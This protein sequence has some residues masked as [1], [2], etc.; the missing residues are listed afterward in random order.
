[1]DAMHP[2]YQ[3]QAVCGWIK[4]GECKTLQTTGK[5][6]RLHFTGALNLMKMKVFIREYETIDA[7]A[8]IDFFKQLEEDSSA[9]AI[10][11]I[12]DNARAHKNQKL[13]RW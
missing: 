3:S 9:Q 1:M 7:D 6:K 13:Y 12:L 10:H 5:Q 2:E 11:I 4:K 8:M